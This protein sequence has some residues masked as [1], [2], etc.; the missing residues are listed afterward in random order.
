MRIAPEMHTAS[1]IRDAPCHAGPLGRL[2]RIARSFQA[3][4]RSADAAH[5][6][7]HQAW[8]RSENSDNLVILLLWR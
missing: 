1:P 7:A 4:L 2:G 6:Y 8:T 3:F 5:A